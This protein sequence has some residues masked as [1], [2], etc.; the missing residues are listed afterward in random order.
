MTSLRRFKATDLFR[1]NDVNL[2]HLTE[3]Y[4]VNFYLQYLSRWPDIFYAAESPEGRLMGYVMGKTEGRGKD[5]HG[6][7]TAITVAPSCRRIGLADQMMHLLEQVS[8]KVY[9]GYFV[10]LFVRISNTVAI[11]MYTKFGYTVYRRVLGYYGGSGAP[12][13]DEDA[14]DMR[15]SLARD[16]DKKSMIPLGRDVRPDEVYF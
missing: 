3:T 14:F 16:K 10:D 2:D 11:D 15:K 7:V 6:H 9:N 8:E 1:F 5:W 4:G 13:A 12:E